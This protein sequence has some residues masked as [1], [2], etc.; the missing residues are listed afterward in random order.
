MIDFFFLCFELFLDFLFSMY[1]IKV[2]KSLSYRPL[3]ELIQTQWAFE[4]ERERE[5]EA[6]NQYG[7]IH[8]NVIYKGKRVVT[9]Q[10]HVKRGT[11]LR[12]VSL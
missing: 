1:G 5:R 6:D 10:M 8:E 12:K 4:R 9:I 11:L 3:V 2:R 7:V